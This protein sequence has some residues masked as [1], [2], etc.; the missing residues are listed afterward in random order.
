MKHSVK[1]GQDKSLVS[2]N[3]SKGSV[4]F[5]DMVM[6]TGIL[7]AVFNLV[8]GKTASGGTGKRAALLKAPK[9]K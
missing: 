4:G 3:V 7:L 9:G 1:K 6:R 8:K 2:I 5:M